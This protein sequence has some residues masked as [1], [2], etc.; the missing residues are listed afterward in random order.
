VLPG[1][2]VLRV[3]ESFE[4][5]EAVAVNCGVATMVAVIEAA[6]VR[7][8]D[9]VVVHGAGLLGLYGIAMARAAGAGAIIAVDQSPER[10]ELAYRFAA[11]LAI[12][13]SSVDVAQAVSQVREACPRG[14]ADIGIEVC[15][16]STALPE[17]LAMLR[18]G[19]RY[20]S[21]GLV[22]PGP[23]VSLDAHTLVTRCLTLVGV[24]NYRPAHLAQALD[25][26]ARHRTEWPLRE[27]VDQRFSLAE[28]DAAFK[29]AAAR[30]LVR[31]AIVP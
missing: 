25:F 17:G 16:A 20:V 8:G 30:R 19:G 7:P 6:A 4:D 13:R 29:H 12:D 9:A 18:T 23:P 10:L 3:P 15:G 5:S 28:V 21:A 2:G 26:V 27:L 22:A 14:G 1:T 11:D 31:P 24:H